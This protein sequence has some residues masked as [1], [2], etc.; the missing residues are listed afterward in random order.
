MVYSRSILG[1][2]VECMHLRSIS[3]SRLRM[4]HGRNK[5]LVRRQAAICREGGM[6]VLN[7]SCTVLQTHAN[8][9]HLG[10][11]MRAQ[12]YSPSYCIDYP[13]AHISQW[14]SFPAIYRC[15]KGGKEKG[16]EGKKG[17]KEKGREGKKGKG[18]AGMS[19]ARHLVEFLRS[20]KRPRRF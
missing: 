17:K 5:G 20:A 9:S 16:R 6:Y 2:H 3:Q 15:R 14:K 13:S 4:R 19:Q 18:R 7:D 12:T 1:M 11:T 8:I 10:A